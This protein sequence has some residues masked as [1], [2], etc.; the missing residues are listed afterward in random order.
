MRFGAV[1]IG[2]AGVEDGYKTD[3]PRWQQVAALAQAVDTGDEQ[4]AFFEVPGRLAPA[5][6]TSRR[7][8]SDDVA[9]TP[10]S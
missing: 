6:R 8:G 7:T 1:R 2:R 4:T 5:T 10:G 3:G 9:G